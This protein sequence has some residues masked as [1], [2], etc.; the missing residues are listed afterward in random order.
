MDALPLS[1][2][3]LYADK[4]VRDRLWRLAAGYKRI[5]SSRTQWVGF[6]GQSLFFNPFLAGVD[7]FF[8]HP[9]A[10][11]G[12]ISRVFAN[13]WAA[14][15]TCGIYSNGRD[16]I[17]RRL[18][19]MG[20]KTIAG[21]F[22]TILADTGYGFAMNLPGFM[23][24]YFL[25]GCGFL[26]SILLG[27][28]ASAAACWTSSIAGGLFDTF[29]ALDSDEPEKRARVPILIRWAV[30]D[31]FELDTRRKLIWLSLAFSIAVT[32]VIYSFAPG[33]LLRAR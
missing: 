3:P 18:G 16:A 14:V 1:S 17:F 6:A 24:N 8:V 25:S 33:G 9:G 15:G 4:S 19:I 26:P 23:V 31:K 5:A 20:S 30:I 21:G 10:A 28:K 2:S 13:A 7:M 22:V 11:H 29:A 32:I 27:F 12:A